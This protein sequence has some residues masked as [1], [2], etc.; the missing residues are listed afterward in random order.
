M[1]ASYLLVAFQA[2]GIT[3]CAAAP[4]GERPAHGNPGGALEPGSAPA[5]ALAEFQGST[6]LGS[7]ALAVL[8]LLAGPL[9]EEE[10]VIANKWATAT[11]TGLA[12]LRGNRGGAAGKQPR[13]RQD[14]EKSLQRFLTDYVKRFLDLLVSCLLWLLVIVMVALYYEHSKDYLIRTPADGPHPPVEELTGDWKYSF[15][16]CCNTPFLCAFSWC[17]PAVRW[18]DT[19]RM[20]DLLGFWVAVVVFF[21]ALV[22]STS[23]AVVGTIP[24]AFIGMHYRQKLRATFEIEH[25][26]CLTVTGDLLAY[27]ICPCLAITQE[28]RT[29]EDAYWVRHPAVF[30][31]RS[32]LMKNFQHHRSMDAADGTFDD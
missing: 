17:C 22:L 23:V 3:V 11:L 32:K 6:A 27:A 19:V 5:E 21:C 13:R 10:P 7:R 26:T 25:G 9:A 18:A 1:K 2:V 30:E 4:A 31:A 12:R 14:E 8:R 29:L 28:A 16:G 15:W 20:A 24:M